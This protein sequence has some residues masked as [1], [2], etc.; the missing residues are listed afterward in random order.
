M[1]PKPS[2]C[3]L[4]AWFQQSIPATDSS[5]QNSCAIQHAGLSSLSSPPPSRHLNSLSESL[6]CPAKQLKS[7]KA[8]SASTGKFFPLPPARFLTLASA[9][10]SDHSLAEPITPSHSA[11]AN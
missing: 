9:R 1:S 8:R 11:R 2:F 4:P 3:P 5:S 7:S 6:A 10:S